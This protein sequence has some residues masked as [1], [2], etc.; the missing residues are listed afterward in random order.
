MNECFMNIVVLLIGL[1]ITA[2]IILNVWLSKYIFVDRVEKRFKENAKQGI[3]K[4]KYYSQSRSVA[5]NSPY[6]GKEGA[7]VELWIGYN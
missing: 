6:T 4:V 5:D 2:F 7:M 3:A 1:L